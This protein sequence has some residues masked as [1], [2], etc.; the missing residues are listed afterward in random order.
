MEDGRSMC[1]FSLY[2]QLSQ[3][4]MADFHGFM[5]SKF[6]AHCSAPWEIAEASALWQAM[7]SSIL[8]FTLWGLRLQFFLTKIGV[9]HGGR[10]VHVRILIIWA[11]QP[12][13][14]GWLSWLHGF[15]IFRSLL[16]SMRGSKC[17][18]TGY[19]FEYVM[20]KI[21]GFQAA[22]VSNHNWGTPKFGPS[23]FVKIS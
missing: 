18:V 22:I 11:A 16:S 13:P 23:S 3:G 2:G 17:I 14:N 19:A 9:P 4:R 15:K 21:V 7:L 20:N 12:G 8:W 10:K 6:S 1:A 5:A